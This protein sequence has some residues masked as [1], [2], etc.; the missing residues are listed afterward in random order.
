[1]AS[2]CPIVT[3]QKESLVV[4]AGVHHW[5]PMLGWRSIPKHKNQNDDIFFQHVRYFERAFSSLDVTWV[6]KRSID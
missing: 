1:M 5:A 2:R 6:N 4:P 3:E